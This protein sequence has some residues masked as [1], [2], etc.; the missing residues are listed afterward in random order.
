AR[1]KENETKEKG[2]SNKAHFPLETRYPTLM[3]CLPTCLKCAAL[4]LDVSPPH[5]FEFSM[6]HYL[7]SLGLVH[8][9]AEVKRMFSNPTTWNRPGCSRSVLAT[10]PYDP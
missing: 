1:P 9:S 10:T 4:F 2:A 8:S 7:W 6:V 3:A 5:A